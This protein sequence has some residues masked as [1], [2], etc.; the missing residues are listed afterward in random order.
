MAQVL[1]CEFSENSKNTFFTGHF[2]TTASVFN[3]SEAATGGVLWKKLFLK[4][5]QL[6]GKHLWFAKFQEH[7]SYG[8]PL[9]LQLY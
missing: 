3:F 9:Q 7:L 1:S 5:L 8:T 6:T 2:R 4:I